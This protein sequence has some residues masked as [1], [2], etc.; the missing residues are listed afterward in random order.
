MRVTI[1][2]DFMMGY[3]G[4]ERVLE[5]MTREFP[6]APVY[7][8]LGR[9]EVAERMGVED[10]LESLIPRHP[11]ILDNHRLLAPVLPA[12]VD[13]FRLPEADVLLTSSSNFAHRLRTANLAPQVCCCHSPLRFAWTMTEGYGESWAPNAPL[14]AAF[15][16][17]AAAMRRSDRRASRRVTQYL[18][19]SRYVARQLERFYGARPEVLGPMVDTHK[20]RPSGRPPGDYFLFCGRLIEPYKQPTIVVEAF[21]R[22]GLRLVVAGDG[23]DRAALERGARPN[24]EFTGDLEDAELVELMQGCLAT[25][26]PSHDDTGLIPLE[27]MA[28]GRPVLAYE[29]GGALETV[30]PGVS[31]AFFPEQSAGAVEQAVRAFDPTHFDAERIRRHAE[32]WSTEHFRARLRRVVERVAT[33]G[34]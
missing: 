7:T 15:D 20:F 25:I 24:V 31:G 27:T 28:C 18:T 8:I 26:F 34:G 33:S 29:G 9:R 3:H 21:R 13:R 22:L 16:V 32:Q 14:R 30:R 19:L 2:H 1:A 17:F 12:V 5:Q 11:R 23:P 4:S 10:R 6:D